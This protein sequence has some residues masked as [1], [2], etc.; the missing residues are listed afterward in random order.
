MLKIKKFPNEKFHPSGSPTLML[1]KLV[2]FYWKFL[3]F[4]LEQFQC[5]KKPINYG[6]LSQSRGE[7]KEKHFINETAGEQRSSEVRLP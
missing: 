5:E 6:N 3:Q 1:E 2:K 4:E 7:E